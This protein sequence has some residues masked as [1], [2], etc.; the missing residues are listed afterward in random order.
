MTFLTIDLS[1]PT[2]NN[3]APSHQELVRATGDYVLEMFQCQLCCFTLFVT[4]VIVAFQNHFYLESHVQKDKKT[5]LPFVQGGKNQHIKAWTVV[6][7][8]LNCWLRLPY[9]NKTL[10]P[11]VII[12]TCFPLSSQS[13]YSSCLPMNGPTSICLMPAK[14][15]PSEISELWK[16]W[17][18]SLGSLHQ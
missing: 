16:S 14:R 17:V 6:P 13:C 11:N 2:G 10:N 8:F 5:L 15:I 9:S 7:C 4:S 12:V 18:C 3:G 1:D